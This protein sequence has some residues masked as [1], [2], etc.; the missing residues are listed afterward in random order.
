VAADR[1]YFLGASENASVELANFLE[2]IRPRLENDGDR[3]GYAGACW[4]LAHG[5]AL[6]SFENQDQLRELLVEQFKF[7]G[8]NKDEAANKAARWAEDFAAMGST[9][10]SVQVRNG[11][12]WVSLFDVAGSMTS[13][14]YDGPYIFRISVRLPPLGICEVGQPTRIYPMSGRSRHVR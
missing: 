14:G 7:K 2:V 5:Y 10:R 3:V 13:E 12:A 9:E 8:L 4:F 11:S 1:V 6:N